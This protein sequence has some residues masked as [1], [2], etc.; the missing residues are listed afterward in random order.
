MEA[1][2][3]LIHVIPAFTALFAVVAAHYFMRA[4]RIGGLLVVGMC[5]FGAVSIMYRVRRTFSVE[6][7]SRR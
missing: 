1:P 5:A 3:Y 4:P 7:S 6:P 2:A